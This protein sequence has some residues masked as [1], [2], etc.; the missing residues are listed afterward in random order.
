MRDG[1]EDV[2]HELAGRRRGVETLLEA[3]RAIDA[4]M[5][6]IRI[7]DLLWDVNA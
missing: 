2:E 3:D 1:A 5:P 4:L 6:R 7:T